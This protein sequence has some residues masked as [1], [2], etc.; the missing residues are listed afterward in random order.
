MD[1][2]MLRDDQWE[3]ITTQTVPTNR[4]AIRKIRREFHG[5]DRLGLRYDLVGI[6]RLMQTCVCRMSTRP[7]KENLLL[8]YI[9]V[10]WF[11]PLVQNI[12]LMSAGGESDK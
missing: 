12:V 4:Y 11:L 9:L 6:N 5:H 1:R 10:P 3:R 2:F 8:L 7:K